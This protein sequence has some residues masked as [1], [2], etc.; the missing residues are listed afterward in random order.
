MQRQKSPARG[1][2]ISESA[3]RTKETS[4]PWHM[5]EG[6]LSERKTTGDEDPHDSDDPLGEELGYGNDDRRPGRRRRP[7]KVEE[8]EDTDRS[9]REITSSILP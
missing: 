3:L 4:K 2:S 8:A 5:K 6:S 7:D 1:R 9:V